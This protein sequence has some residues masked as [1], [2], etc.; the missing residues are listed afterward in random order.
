M[1]Y[2]QDSFN[3]V[4]NWLERLRM[5][6]ETPQTV[7]VGNKC[8]LDKVVD[9]EVSYKSFVNSQRTKFDCI[10]H[11]KQVYLKAISSSES[12]SVIL[13]KTTI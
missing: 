7:I 6:S 4:E 5:Y 11:I 13:M 3:H 8:D 10:V 1:L 2:L 12:K 9:D